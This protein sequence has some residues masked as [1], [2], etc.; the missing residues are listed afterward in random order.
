MVKPY[1][2]LQAALEE[3][4]MSVIHHPDVHTEAEHEVLVLVGL[5]GLPC[6]FKCYGLSV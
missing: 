4:N 5:P 1:S 3:D 6:F 2:N